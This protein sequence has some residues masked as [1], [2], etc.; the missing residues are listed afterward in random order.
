MS[1]IVAVTTC[2]T[3]IAHTF[4]AAEALKKAAGELGHTIKVETMGAVGV[5]NGLTS[6][7][8][9][10]AELVIVAADAKVDTERFSGKRVYTTST[11]AAIKNGREVIETA[12]REAKTSGSSY[13][14]NVVKSKSE[15]SAQRKGIYKHLMT[16]VSY[17]LPLVVAGG[18]AIALSFVFGIKAFEVKGSLAAAFMDIGSA[19]M[20]LMV[21]ILAAYIA[22]SIA[23]RPGLTPGLVGGI[24]AVKIGA[25][26]LGGLIAGLIAG[27]VALFLKKYIKLP[28]TLEGLKPI[29]IIPFLSSLAI[30]L[31][32]I[33]VLGGPVKMIM[34][35][36]TAFLTGM[37]AA[38]ATLMGLVLG[39]M[40]ALDMGGPVNKTAYMFAT[41]LLASNI[42]APMAA[43]MAAGMTPPLGLALATFLNKKKYST[44][45]REAG[46]AAA[47]LGISFITEGAIPFAAAD[48]FRVIPSIMVGS[49]VT[50]ALSG[51]FGCGL[52]VPHGG[53]FVLPIPHAV[54]RLGLYV[55]AIAAG[56]LVTALIV[57]ILKPNLDTT[58][59]NSQ[60]LKL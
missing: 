38:N 41:G 37:S 58:D 51:L 56:T 57:N 12:F 59:Y 19:A 7:D 6:E 48:P 5:E 34:D 22:Y 40:M 17:M 55:V 35:A 18:L 3:G 36:L 33:F 43:V 1:K 46:K 25:G 28:Q 52:K 8:I 4:M 29:L 49:A 47:V 2:P 13:L 9:L 44:E 54:G 60:T 21:P 26:F 42:Y 20:G 50:G 39:A 10:Q 15:R 27:Y 30:G 23:D 11:G 53:I 24:L 32:M 16:G 14:D 45:E 31:L